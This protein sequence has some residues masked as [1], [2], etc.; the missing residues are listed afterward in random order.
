MTVLA[1]ILAFSALCWTTTPQQ[2][3]EVEYG[4]KSFRI[5]QTPMKSFW[6]DPDDDNETQKP[7]MPDFQVDSTANWQGYQAIWEIRR[8]KL[9]LKSIKGRIKDEVVKNE[10]VIR[11]KKFPC[12][13]SWFTGR[14]YLAVGDYDAERRE[15]ESVL[16]FSIEEGDVKKIRYYEHREIGYSWNG[17]EE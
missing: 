2:L 10:A 13:A 14:I 17:I 3:D 12:E 1:R 16:E 9:W 5:L 11:E 4:R 8:S 7:R 15:Y 6:A